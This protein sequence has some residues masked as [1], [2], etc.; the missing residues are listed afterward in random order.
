MSS[1]LPQCCELALVHRTWL[2]GRCE[3]TGVSLHAGSLPG[4]LHS[5]CHAPC[6]GGCLELNPS[7]LQPPPR[8]QRG[9]RP[10]L[11]TGPHRRSRPPAAPPGL[12]GGGGGLLEL[13]APGHGRGAAGLAGGAVG[14]G[15]TQL[16]CR[17]RMQ[18]GRCTAAGMKHTRACDSACMHSC[19]PFSWLI[20]CK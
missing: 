20:T 12:A 16:P 11:A 8:S 13:A 3:C 7:A 10:A 1:N 9:G 5:L 17:Q 6:T 18:A 14:C 15:E 19:Q 2:G 4:A